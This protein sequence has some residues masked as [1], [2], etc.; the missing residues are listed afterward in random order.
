MGE[1]SSGDSDCIATMSDL[2]L[3]LDVRTPTNVLA[4]LLNSDDCRVV[5]AAARHPCLSEDVWDRFGDRAAEDLLK[6]PALRLAFFTNQ[7]LFDSWESAYQIAARATDECYLCALAEH[8]KAG[9]RCNVVINPHTPIYLFDRLSKD[10]YWG[11]RARIAR[12]ERTPFAILER[13][14]SDRCV[15]TDL[16]YNPVTPLALLE[17]LSQNGCSADKRLANDRL[18]ARRG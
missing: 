8:P 9:V 16:I 3:A 15:H 10:P 1:T 13:L 7:R 4:R 12:S 17:W 6:N 18:R 5:R 2:D 11:V 14:L